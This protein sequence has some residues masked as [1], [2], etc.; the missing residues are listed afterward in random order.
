[1]QPLIPPFIQQKLVA[2]DL[3]GELEAFTLNIDLSGFTPLTE[4]LM[5][6]GLSGAEQLSVVLNDVFQPL[7]SLAYSAGGFIPYFAGDAFTA[8]FPLPLDGRHAMHLLRTAER[9]RQLFRNRGKEFGNHYTFG[10]K[11]GIAAG[12]VSYGIV[13]KGLRAFYFRGPAIDGASNCQSLAGDQ[14]IVVNSYV[15]SLIEG[16]LVYCEEIDAEA[17]R[18][19][20][21]VPLT[22]DVEVAP[23]Q[24]P[25]VETEIATAFLPP[26]VVRYDQ[27]GEFR[28]VVSCFLSFD[29][30]RTHEDLD[31]F[32]TVVLDQVR[33]FGGYFKE[34]DYGDKGALMVIFFGAPVSYENNVARAVEFALTVQRELELLSNQDDLPFRFRMGMTVGT[35]FT[36]IV[37]GQERAQYACVGNR[38]NLAARIM[39]AAEWQ[40]VLVDE[41][42]A[43][44]PQFRFLPRG[45]IRYKGV[46]E[47]VPTY[48]LEGRRQSLGKPDYGGEPIGRDEEVARLLQFATPLLEGKPGGIAYVFGEAGIGKS[49]LTH[50]LRH[51]LNQRRPFNWL[52]G[53]CDQILR[54][55]FNPF[56]FLLQRMFRQ[57]M[58][59]NAE[60]NLRRF[61]ARIGWMQINLQQRK[62]P[63][64]EVLVAELQRT[65][66]LLAAQLGLT[67]PDSLYTR[68]DAQGRYQNT[69][70]A[71]VN[72]IIAECLIQPTVLELEDTHWIDQESLVVVRELL[73][74]VGDLPLL[75]VATARPDDDGQYPRLLKEGFKGA[76]ELP[77]LEIELGALSPESVRRFAETTLG[78][79]VS[80]DTLETLLRAT[81]S[82]PFYLE[83]ILEYFRESELLEQQEDGLLHLSDE[84]IKLSTSITSILTARIDRLSDMVREIVKAAA[85]IGREF[86]LPVLSEVMRADE[87]FEDSDNLMQ[88]LREQIRVAERGQIW[89]A[90]NELRY[91]FKHSLLREA[92]YGMQLTTRVQ[93]LHRQIAAAIEK[94]YADSLEERY[95]DLA[96]HYGQSGDTEKTIEY[97][98][99]AASYARANYQNQQA[100][101]LYDRLIK[102]MNQQADQEVT[103]HIFLSQGS[104]Y[105]IVGRWEDARRA[106]EEAR[107]LA[108]SSRDVI[109]LGRA[110][111]S[112]GHLHLL[113][114]DYEL[115]MEY[116]KV[117]AG[118]F[119]SVDD[120][121]GIAKA[122]SNM[123]NLF[124]R[125]NH[126]DRALTYFQRSLESGLSQAGTT[127]S[128]ST[129]S[130]LG[131][132]Y[133]NLGQYEEA[134]RVIKE[135]IPLHEESRDSMG[136]ATLHTNL[137]IVYFDSGDYQRSLEHHHRGLALARE[138]GNRRLQA[139]GLGSL[140][141]INERQG[142]YETAL[143]LFEQD[144]KICYELGDRQ[145]IAVT[146]ALIGD[147]YSVMGHF[148][149]AINH[150]DRS[151]AISSDLGYRKGV[152]KAVNTLGDIYY[153]QGDY[154]LSLKY[155]NQ[156]IE[157]ARATNNR[158]V[159][160]ASLYEKGQVLLADGKLEELREVEQEALEVA[161]D[162]GN[163]DVL[164]GAR[165]LHARCLVA[166][167]PA[168][169]PE[170]RQILDELLTREVLTTEQQA[171]VNLVAYQLS[172]KRD[173]AAREA[174]LKLYRQLHAET[175]K[176][177][178]T[179]HLQ[180]LE[181]AEQD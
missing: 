92:V 105:E 130:H 123:G 108:K 145:G 64:A 100:L 46:Q 118:L 115:A 121:F 141:S 60:Q 127:T 56:T 71:I 110:N 107:R 153:L 30:I 42:I 180:E 73:R 129:I 83:Q 99:K 43:T 35:A 41:E 168:N 167:D 114:G 72:L 98:N 152:A 148:T 131:L 143:E 140:G 77:T 57:S 12:T 55:P 137:G 111:N 81:N 97:L 28:T 76:S 86:D 134:I 15:Q 75:V 16:R 9:A 95:V 38:V 21:D 172:G 116:L 1:M 40:A 133:M 171:E 94:I 149:K 27:A 78:G 39:S 146:E 144:L 70:D 139:I 101:E 32:A 106:Y 8:I 58:D 166:Y 68:L 29:A 37:G 93:Q 174:A 159:L 3:H 11:A 66:S 178:Y 177:V 49:R 47:P 96:F 165:L 91:I 7:V 59:L 117:A 135:Q 53:S 112:L 150:L 169:L 14:E 173:A 128:A 126:Y 74:R 2:G 26:E 163:P 154:D 13:G 158:L 88:D 157:I 113:K 120:I 65:E 4:S 162:L 151:L 164:Y 17:F 80:Q 89:S 6:Q 79:P 61:E 84:S 20:G 136:L 67:L 132:T 31:R 23:L 156:A 147:L 119:E 87:G 109:L 63:R 22:T 10:I 52:L 175:P 51:Q 142:N 181:A 122:Y 50:E 24:L 85:V 34:V 125:T 179:F 176:F 138:L 104:V 44:T 48:S 33:D 103:V 18:V 155:Y 19:L 25:E 54:K 36:G 124:F 90:M 62:D 5:E 69:I 45:D 82:N 170:A 160:G 102:K 161:E